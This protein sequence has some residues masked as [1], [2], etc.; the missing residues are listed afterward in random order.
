MFLV[1][2]HHPSNGLADLTLL[3]G[4]EGHA[5]TAHKEAHQRFQKREVVRS[6]IELERVE[7]RGHTVFQWVVAPAHGPH[8]DRGPQ[9]LVE[10]HARQWLGGGV[11]LLELGQEEGFQHGLTGAGLPN[12]HCVCQFLV[13]GV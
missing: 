10:Q 4:R 7:A 2:T 1:S 8:C 6:W 12:D 5:F 13:I 11:E 3:G 9:V